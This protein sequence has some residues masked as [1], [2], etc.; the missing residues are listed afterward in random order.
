MLCL[1]NYNVC[2]RVL[3]PVFQRYL[4]PHGGRTITHQNASTPLRGRFSLP[5]KDLRVLPPKQ[6][7]QT[8]VL[9]RHL[10]A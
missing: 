10:T 2:M 6:P 8:P 3:R 7:G 5:T 1:L 9:L 4:G